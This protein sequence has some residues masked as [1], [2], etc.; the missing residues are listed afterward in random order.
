MGQFAKGP[1][2]VL[3]GVVVGGVALFVGFALVTTWYICRRKKGLSLLP[4]SHS[5]SGTLATLRPGTP[6]SIPISRSHHEIGSS[7][8]KSAPLPPSGKKSVFQIADRQWT[9]PTV[10]QR[11]QNFQRMLSHRLNLSH[12]EFSV[13]SVKQKEQPDLGVIKPELYKQASV[14]SLRSE[15]VPCGKLFFSLRYSQEEASL[16]VNVTRA[17]NLPAKDFSGTSDPYVKVYLMPDR[18]TKHQ[19]KVHRK[20]LNPEFNEK[21]S[22]TVLYEDLSGRSLQFNIYDFDRFS[23]HDVIGAVKV[24]DIL[25]EGSLSKETFFVRDI[26]ASQQEKADIGEVMLSLCYLPTAGRLTLTVVKARNLKAMDITG[27]ADPYVKVCLMCQG[28]RIKKRKTSVQRN[29]L[30]P[31]FNEAL[32]FDVP[33]ESVEDVHLLVKVVDYDRIG[34]DE[35]MGCVTL[36]PKVGGQGREHWYEML[37]T[38][39]RPV[40]QWYPLMEQPP[41]PAPSNGKCCLRQRQSTED[42]VASDNNNI[43]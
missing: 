21:F 26:Y 35:F 18:K 2:P 42:S 9:L 37:E 24:K 14:D 7:G 8:P 43:G 11:H 12:I 16:V 13:Q 23:R 33:Q 1:D 19:T 27:Y 28:R 22:F 3:V 39:R 15:H 32:V 25:G 40:A 10:S 4:T 5:A 34:S 29:T 30:N 6:G 17:E 31:V 20:T 36:G 41:L 38:P